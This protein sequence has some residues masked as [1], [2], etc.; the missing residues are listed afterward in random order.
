V[1]EIGGKIELN[2]AGRLVLPSLP[3]GLILK[4]QLEWMLTS[5][6]DGEQRAE[7]SYLG[8]QH[9]LELRL[10]GPPQQDRR[11]ARSDGMGHLSE[12]LRDRIQERGP[13]T[14][15][16][17]REYREA[18]IRSKRQIAQYD[19]NGLAPAPQF[20]QRDLFEYKIYSLQRRT[21]VQ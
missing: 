16:R 8:R 6:K 3:E 11:P 18:G 10:R 15:R 9:F 13:Q 14:G 7:I 19:E 21:D 12:Q 1:A 20:Q 17:R 4:P 2:P 5:A